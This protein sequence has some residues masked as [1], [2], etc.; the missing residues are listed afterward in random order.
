[1]CDK[2]WIKEVEAEKEKIS[3]LFSQFKST[4]LSILYNFF[5]IVRRQI[6]VITLIFMPKY[7]TF[8]LKIHIILTLMSLIYSS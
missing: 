8:Q 5:F 1:M 3:G 2:G 6:M 7:G 4:K